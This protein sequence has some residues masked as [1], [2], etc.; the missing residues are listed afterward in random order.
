[1]SLR[2]STS[3]ESTAATT[4]PQQLQRPRALSKSCTS[5][6]APTQPH[7]VP[8]ACPRPAPFPPPHPPTHP[9]IPLSCSCLLNYGSFDSHH[10]ERWAAR[11]R[12]SGRFFARFGMSAI[13][14]Q[15]SSLTR[16]CSRHAAT[17][18][19]GKKQCESSFICAPTLCLAA[20]K[21]RRHLPAA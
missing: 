2:S 16:R 14:R 3:T 4:R 10:R 12:I 21:L 19:R 6:C 13:A 15:P 7:V 17:P 20:G 8:T 9:P 18:S 11:R 5:R 1:M